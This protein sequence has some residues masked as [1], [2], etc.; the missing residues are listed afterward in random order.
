MGHTVGVGAVEMRSVG[1]HDICALPGYY[2][3]CSGNTLPTFRDNL[4]APS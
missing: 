4:S 3:A 2:V 1:A